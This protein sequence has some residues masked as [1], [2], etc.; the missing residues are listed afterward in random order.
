MAKKNY[1]MTGLAVRRNGSTFTLSWKW[2]A[3]V[4]KPTD[5][6]VDVQYVLLKDDEKGEDGTIFKDSS[7][8]VKV[9]HAGGAKGATSM[10]LTV[11]LSDYYPNTITSFSGIAWRVRYSTKDWAT[12]VFL[13]SA[14][15]SPVLT[16]SGKTITWSVAR[17]QTDSAPFTDVEYETLSSDGITVTET[18]WASATKRTGDGTGSVNLS[19]PTNKVAWFRIRS[20]GPK[21]ATAWVYEKAYFGTPYAPVFHHATRNGTEATVVFNCLASEMKYFD[22]LTIQ[23]CIGVP[24]SNMGLPASP[25]WRTGTT[26]AGSTKDKT[27]TATFTV[28]TLSE[29]QGIW[30]RATATGNG[31]ETGGAGLG[32]MNT[33]KSPTF[34]D[35]T[36]DTSTQVVTATFTNRSTVPDAKVALIFSD[37]K[38]LA[39]NG[40]T[41][42]TATYKLSP[43]VTEATFG[44]FAYVGDPNSNPKAKSETV[45]QTEDVTT[46]QAPA[47]ISGSESEITPGTPSP[48]SASGGSA[49]YTSDGE[50]A[51]EWDW[52][53]AT[54]N[55][56]VISW[57]DNIN[58][59]TSTDEPSEY[60]IRSKTTR[61]L[62]SGL[63][64]GKTWYFKIRLVKFASSSTEN[65]EYGPWS[66]LIRIDLTSAPEVPSVALSAKVIK[67]GDALTVSWGYIS[68]DETSQAAATIFV[69]GGAVA[70]IEGASQS[71][72][73]TPE[74]SAGDTHSI[75]VKTI[76][77]SGLANTS[78]AVSVDVAD[79]P[80]ISVTSSLVSGE[81][82]AMPLALTVTGAGVGGQTLV[83]ITRDGAFS[84]QRPDELMRDGFDGETI[85]TGKFSGELT[86]FRIS[87]EMLS[88]YLDDGACY[89]LTCTVLDTYGQKVEEKTSFKVAWTHQAEAPTA[90][91][92]EDRAE[93]MVIIY[94]IAP[95]G[96]AAGDKCDIYRLSTDRPELIAKG[97]P[98][99]QAMADPYPASEGG[100]RVVTVTADGD[101]LGAEKPAW[102]DYEHTLKVS[103]II[104]DYDEG[105]IELPFN[106][107]VANTWTKDFKRTTYL[108]GSVQGDWNRGVLRDA[109]LTTVTLKRGDLARIEALRKLA[110]APQICHVRTPDGS[111]YVADVQVSESGSYSDLLVSFN[112]T[113]QK[114]DSKGWDTISI[115]DLEREQEGGLSPLLDDDFDPVRDATGDPIFGRYDIEEE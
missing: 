106:N 42:L 85:Y 87:P 2:A 27:V 78:A 59:W 10:D 75:T 84:V 108:N 92:I 54:A 28:G 115:T 56:A 80:S 114:V 18:D 58:A 86:D 72:T 112:L 64:R 93:G 31:S 32:W 51:L 91:I 95:A 76:S 25:T 41:S 8:V 74:W 61:W 81:L 39:A 29:D 82:K 33:L 101:Y 90:S 68:T 49:T 40:T 1:T 52:T 17:T 34:T 110:T 23:Y 53:W 107:A 100:Y 7:R 97:V 79:A 14:P 62:V 12:N 46:P 35:I 5:H 43:N 69:D 102:A 15:A 11:N 55:G 65:D 88:G 67:P 48:S 66:E 83:S 57:S 16:K 26:L 38:V 60:T 103:G 37:G 96:Y 113:V 21:G 19:A 94:P 109:N 89:F 50:I 47:A 3:D 45:W 20:R 22:S 71:Y 13:I 36:W 105:R 44:L 77:A 24:S 99:M 111:S 6:W 4:S 9:G 73:F 70:D 63:S 30:F 98:F 104:L